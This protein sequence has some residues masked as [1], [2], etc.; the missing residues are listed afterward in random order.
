MHPVT[1]SA[2]FLAISSAF[3]LYGLSYETKQLEARVAQQQRQADQ[4]RSDIAV[5]KAERAHLLRPARI[6]PLARAQ[7]LAPPADGQIVE[8][9]PGA[10]I[11]TGTISR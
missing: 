9:V 7:G 6:E 2:A 3:L 5:L 4:A 1:V 11:Q 8:T 10:T